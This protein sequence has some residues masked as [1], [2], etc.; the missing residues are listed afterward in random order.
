[1]A[2]PWARLVQNYI[3]HPKFLALTANAICL[4][5][6]GKNYCDMHATD[7]MIPR[8]A[9]KTFRFAGA[10]SIEALLRS[11][12][13]KP[14]GEAYA[15]LWEPHIVGYRMHDYLEHNDC[16]DEVKQRL[17]DADDAA[18]LRRL[19]NKE[20]QRK[21]RLE[22]KAK[23]EEA[24]HAERNARNGYVTPVTSTPTETVTEAVTETQTMKERKERSAPR[25]HTGT[26]FEGALPR[27]H[28]N[29]VFCDPDFSVCVP[30]AVHAKL[31][32]P[33]SRRFNGDRERTHAELKAW[34][35][36][37]A[38]SLPPE[39]TPPSDAFKFWQARFDAEWATKD[40]APAGSVDW[41]A[42][43]QKGPSVR[44]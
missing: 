43:A 24:R 33:M 31:I 12:G 20:R 5:L 38:A 40:A 41:A 14:N 3:N 17:E 13:V 34:Y 18:E 6:E 44:S 32:G 1:M 28:V 15:S 16:H 36:R 11:C 7:G 9:L 29:H 26:V 21:F 35:G 37:V 30:S 8:E 19:A 10:K 25:A 23:L 39:F 4:W 2:K 27:E 42:I 22:R